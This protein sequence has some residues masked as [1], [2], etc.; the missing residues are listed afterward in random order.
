LPIRSM[1]RSTKTRAF[2]AMSP[3]AHGPGSQKTAAR[4]GLAPW[5]SLPPSPF[6]QG[7]CHRR[8]RHCRRQTVPDGQRGPAPHHRG[9]LCP[10]DGG[11]LWPTQFSRPLSSLAPD[12]RC[13]ELPQPW[14][15]PIMSSFWWYFTIIHRMIESAHL[16]ATPPHVPAPRH[17]TRVLRDMLRMPLDRCPGLSYGRR[18]DGL[19]ET[20]IE[21]KTSRRCHAGVMPVRDRRV[22]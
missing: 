1:P 8:K 17:I 21:K 6:L 9:A 5:G 4:P 11:C 13:A 22:A 10:R 18:H 20:A 15:N 16:S 2:R 19:C 12:I 3:R 14:L 7:P